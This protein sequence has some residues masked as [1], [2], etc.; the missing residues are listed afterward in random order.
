MSYHMHE[1]SLLA[2]TPALASSMP[3][4]RLTPSR[5]IHTGLLSIHS[6]MSL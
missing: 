2:A 1:G 3:H 6:A 5:P 4:A